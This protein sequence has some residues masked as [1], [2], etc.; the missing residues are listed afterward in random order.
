MKIKED[1]ITFF[2]CL[3]VSLLISKVYGE[4]KFSV[5]A[6]EAPMHAADWIVQE[7][8]FECTLKQEIPLLG[9]ARF[10]H[11]AGERLRFELQ[12]FDR[13]LN[14]GNIN[15]TSIPPP[16]NFDSPTKE[17]GFLPLASD[18]MIAFE[19]SWAKLLMTE[20]LIGMKPQFTGEA[21][22]SG[23]EA[24]Q[25]TLSPL[26]FQQAY[27]SYQRCS[28]DLLPVNF[29]Q[30]NRTTIFWPSGAK[31]LTRDAVAQLDNIVLYTEADASIVGF[32]VDSFTDTAGERRDNLLLSEERAFLVT[33][34]L[35]R[36]GI[37]PETIATRAH[38]EREQYLIVN[39]EKSS[40]DRDRNR[41]VNV[42]MLRGNR[43]A[44]SQ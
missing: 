1:H 20:M 8:V 39:P 9:E 28:S 35:I 40:A 17:F 3:F 7:S 4:E 23:F 33:N 41:R 25:V 44:S 26:R 14:D 11:Q 29:A 27:E 10:Y 36:K 12:V 32:E 2:A 38:G 31:A 6:Y 43:L 42:V 30:I 18:G 22:Q 37:D 21:F 16:W 34:Y 24:V 19:Q 5:R 15:L 13:L